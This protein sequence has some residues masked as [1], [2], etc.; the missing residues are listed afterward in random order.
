MADFWRPVYNKLA[1]YLLRLIKIT[2]KFEIKNQPECEPV[3]YGFWHRNLIYGTL[4]RAGDKLVIMVS[5]SKDGELIAGPLAELGYALVRG[6]SSRQGSEALKGIVRYAQTHSPA[7]TPDGPKGPLGKVEPGLFHIALL[8]K[9]PIV[10]VAC[11]SNREW[12]FN[13]WDKFRFPKP[14]A[15]V[16]I[17]YSDP[18]YVWSK[19][20]IPEAEVQFRKFLADMEKEFQGLS[21]RQTHR[22]GVLGSR[23]KPSS[24]QK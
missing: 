3:V 23:P 10:A 5:A 14:F 22:E 21:G 20:D 9:I 19:A 4:L 6:S 1:S 11:D 18:I 2:L 15:R 12:I 16:K 7:I 8:A 24:D 17:V 13:S